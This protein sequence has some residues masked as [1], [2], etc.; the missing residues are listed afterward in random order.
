MICPLL[1][2]KTAKTKIK[3]TT[4]KLTNQGQRGNFV[5]SEWERRKKKIV[6]TFFLSVFPPIIFFQSSPQNFLG[7]VIHFKED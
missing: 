5:V 3:L 4:V 2:F 1:A 6:S 7:I